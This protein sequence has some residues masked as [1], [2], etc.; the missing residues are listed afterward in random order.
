MTVEGKLKN[1]IQHQHIHPLFSLKTK[2]EFQHG[3]HRIKGA[4]LMRRTLIWVMQPY[5]VQPDFDS[6]SHIHD[7]EISSTNN[8]QS[9]DLKP[10][11]HAET[12][13]ETSPCICCVAAMPRHG[14]V[15]LDFCSSYFHQSHKPSPFS[16][17]SLDGMSST[18]CPL[19]SH[20]LPN[21]LRGGCW[22]P[23]SASNTCCVSCH[24]VAL[25]D[26]AASRRNDVHQAPDHSNTTGN[27]SRKSA[28]SE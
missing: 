9:E 27:S 5:C 16:P 14:R 12:A 23:A 2:R 22:R 15:D 17:S 28:C 10:P 18:I 6:P 19:P 20:L 11:R 4:C 1:K 26:V 25:R 3:F 24:N 21:M 13:S 8:R 7:G